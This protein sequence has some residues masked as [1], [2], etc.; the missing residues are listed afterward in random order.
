MSGNNLTVFEKNSWLW[1]D[2][3][4]MDLSI[5]TRHADL[6]KKIDEDGE[7]CGVIVGNPVTDNKG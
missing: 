5:G 7:W 1:P 3:R 2:S 4:D 6:L